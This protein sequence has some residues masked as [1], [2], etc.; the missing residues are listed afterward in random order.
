[1]TDEEHPL[2]VVVAPQ[3]VEQLV[4]PV[5][6]LAIALAA[7]ERLVDPGPPLGV[8]LVDGG[9]GQLAEVALP[10]PRVGAAGQLDPAN[11][12]STVCTARCRSE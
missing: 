3:L 12:M 10:Q 5:G 2:P 8:H 6:D 7:G 11:A 9:A 4:D 1:M